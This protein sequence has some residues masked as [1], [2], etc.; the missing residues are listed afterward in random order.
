MYYLALAMLSA[1]WATRNYLELARRNALYLWLLLQKRPAQR[2]GRMR[3]SIWP[4]VLLLAANHLLCCDAA[5][6]STTQN[7]STPSSLQILFQRAHNQSGLLLRAAQNKSAFILHAAGNKSKIA[8]HAAGARSAA[9]LRDSLAA[10]KRAAREAASDV[11]RVTTDFALDVGDAAM[12][13]AR[14]QKKALADGWKRLRRRDREV[15]RILRRAASREWYLLLQVRRKASKSKLRE[16]YRRLAKRVHPDKT[17]DDRATE[18][19]NTL[20]DAYELLADSDQ[21]A[22]YDKQLAKDDEARRR[23]REKRRAATRRA[24]YKALRV[25][26]EAALK[27]GRALAVAAMANKRVAAVIVA[28]LWL[29][30]AVPPPDPAAQPL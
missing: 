8:L 25:G 7:S 23:Q 22:R 20:R 14:R 12:E 6:N 27:A 15:S 5:T 17:R 30:F 11:A 19:F 13:T 29:L 21:R 2:C 26:G 4:I 24:A 18:A 9:L 1:C 28:L 3:R 16:A 10:S